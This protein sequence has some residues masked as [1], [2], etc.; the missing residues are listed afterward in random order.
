MKIKLV[1]LSSIITSI[2]I[3]TGCTPDT[4]TPTALEFKQNMQLWVGYDMNKYIQQN[5]YPSGSF[6]SPDGDKIY[7]YTDSEPN[8][9][10]TYTHHTSYARFYSHVHTS[11]GEHRTA[12][13]KWWIFVDSND[14]IK[15]I[16]DKSN[17]CK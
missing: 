5:G 15:H 3:I 12:C 14:I 9:T 1:L 10:A 8:T 2:F 13:C 17:N 16:E 4:P 11:G 6:T 7:V